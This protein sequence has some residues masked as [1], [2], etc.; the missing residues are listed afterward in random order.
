MHR[1]RSLCMHF[2]FLAN[3]HNIT[4]T[5]YI[6]FDKTET[7]IYAPTSAGTAGQVLKSNGSGAPS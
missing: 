6:F 2:I 7:Y 3:Y 4:H 1:E 5:N